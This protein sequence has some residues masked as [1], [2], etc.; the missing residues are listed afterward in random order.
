V[1]LDF[2]PPIQCRSCLLL[3]NPH[4]ISLDISKYLFIAYNN[5]RNYLSFGLLQALFPAIFFQGNHR[6]IPTQ[7]HL[8]KYTNF[9][10]KG[11]SVALE[12]FTYLP[13]PALSS[14]CFINLVVSDL[15]STK[16]T[17]QFA[18]EY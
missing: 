8:I 2:Y 12:C 5:V 1:Q 6:C 14:I 15:E 16:N 17:T 3:L 10:G 11:S 18:L 4:K 13:Q 9:K 7:W